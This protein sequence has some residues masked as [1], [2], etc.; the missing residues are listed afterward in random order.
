MRRGTSEA[1]SNQRLKSIFTAE[2]FAEWVER[3]AR[4]SQ[5]YRKAFSR[6][7]RLIL[8]CKVACGW[9]RR[10]IEKKTGIAQRQVGNFYNKMKEWNN[11]G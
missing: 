8:F 3:E 11:N 4:V 9:S 10:V 6:T 7:E 2:V 5:S 1:P